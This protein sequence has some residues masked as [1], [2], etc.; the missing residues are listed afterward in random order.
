MSTSSTIDFS[1]T[2]A[3][4]IDLPVVPKFTS[5]ILESYQPAKLFQDNSKRITSLHFDDSGQY[6]V[7][8]SEDDSLQIYD[9]SSGTP[10]RTLFSKKY[11]CHLARFTHRGPHHVLYASTHES[12]ER[13]GADVIRFLDTAQNKYLTYFHGHKH[14]VISLDVSSLDDAFVSSSLDGTVRIWDT[15][16]PNCQGCISLPPSHRAVVAIDPTSKVLGIGIY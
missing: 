10:Y 4:D 16:T 1:N 9:C 3:P 13:A 5:S 12:G 7:T 8:A 11:G 6:L 14:S 15:R 2:L